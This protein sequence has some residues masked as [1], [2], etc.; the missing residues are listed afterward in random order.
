[1]SRGLAGPGVL[2]VGRARRLRS[3]IVPRTLGLM[4]RCPSSAPCRPF[5]LL[6]NAAVHAS[7]APQGTLGSAGDPIQK[8]VGTDQAQQSV[9]ER[10]ARAQRGEAPPR[11]TSGRFT[12][13]GDAL[14]R[15][16]RHRV[17]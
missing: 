13:T 16:R 14:G 17:Y 12:A 15:G 8:D 11:T 2:G 4:R 3:Q 9:P 5:G 10:I 7:L 6:D 1:M